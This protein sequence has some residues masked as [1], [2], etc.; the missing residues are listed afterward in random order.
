[1]YG[2]ED[3]SETQELNSTDVT[4]VVTNLNP[5]NPY[6]F[7]VLAFT[8]ELS[9]RS[10]NDTTITAEAGN[11]YEA[12]LYI[13]PVYYYCSSA[14]T[15]PLNV[16]AFNDSSTSIVV[17]WIPPMIPNGIIRSYRVQFTRMNDSIVDNVNT[18][19]TSV[20]IEMLE[21]FTTYMVQVF[22][23]TVEEGDGS[24]EVTV[25]TDEDS[26]LLTYLSTCIHVYNYNC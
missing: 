22:A 15:A 4:I 20:I 23:T 2:L 13:I 25:T 10:E 6:I 18:F 7:Y 11:T 17:T 5:F 9:D 26:E 16:A 19:N 3:S 21:K 12:I 14:P 8:V 1:M 24:D